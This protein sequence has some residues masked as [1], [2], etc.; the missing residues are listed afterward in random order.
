MGR[1]AAERQPA[2]RGAVLLLVAAAA[3]ETAA[4]SCTGGWDC[5]ELPAAVDANLCD[6]APVKPC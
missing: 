3:R 6:V 2:R 1:R 5:A 4:G